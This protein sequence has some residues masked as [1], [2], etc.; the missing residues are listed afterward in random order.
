MI[1]FTDP[2][3]AYLA[4]LF[5]VTAIDGEFN[6]LEFQQSHI[7]L[8]ELEAFK[9][10]DDEAIA[11]YLIEMTNIFFDEFTD[12]DG[13]DMEEAQDL[14]GAIKVILPADQYETAYVVAVEAAHADGLQEKEA[15][16]LVLLRQSLGIDPA[17]A[18]KILERYEKP[19]PA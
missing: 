2:V 18:A 19:L 1:Q 16:F 7:K 12:G 6:T 10:H 17:R 3:E 15:Y 4:I 14:I 13:L 11:N 9:R 5:A 8:N